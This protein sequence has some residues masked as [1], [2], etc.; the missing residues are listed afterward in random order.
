MYCF[1]NENNGA[2]IFKN[3]KSLRLTK[4]FCKETKTKQNNKKTLPKI[5]DY[6]PWLKATQKG[7]M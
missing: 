5:Q 4:F 2:R 3:P 1:H 7:P 6:I